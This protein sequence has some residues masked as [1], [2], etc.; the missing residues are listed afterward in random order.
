MTTR[1]CAL[2]T[3]VALCGGLVFLHA[4]SPRD[5]P[6][7]VVTDFPLKDTQGRA[8]SLAQFKEKKALVLVF[9]GTECPV[10]N[11]FLPRLNELHKEFAG[12]G[13]QFLAVNANRQDTLQRIADHAKK[14]DI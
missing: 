4:D 13:V 7:K 6:G 14:H 12:R 2:L 8:V 5:N 1:T 11:L 9:L 10:N 3:S